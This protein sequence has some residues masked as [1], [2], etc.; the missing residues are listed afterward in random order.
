[1]S[2]LSPIR[3]VCRNFPFFK[4]GEANAYRSNVGAIFDPKRMSKLSFPKNHR[5][6]LSVKCRSYLLSETYVEIVFSSKKSK[7][8]PIE[9]N[10]G[11]ISYPKRMSKLSFLQKSRG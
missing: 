7:L 4:K 6:R 2:E 8:T 9:P 10:V 3:N 5:Y 11:A 1:M